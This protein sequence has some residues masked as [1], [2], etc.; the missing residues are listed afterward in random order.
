MSQEKNK[1]RSWVFAKA[2]KIIKW[3]L[4]WAFHFSKCPTICG[5]KIQLELWDLFFSKIYIIK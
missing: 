2:E 4:E 3:Q 1:K 5:G